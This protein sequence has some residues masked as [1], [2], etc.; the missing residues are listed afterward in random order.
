[1]SQVA[2]FLACQGDLALN[3]EAVYP[4]LKDV[5]LAE[6]PGSSTMKQFHQRYR[7]QL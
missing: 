4:T 2:I 7:P 3:D 6:S 1:M 5:T